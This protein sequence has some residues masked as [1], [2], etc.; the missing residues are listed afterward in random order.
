M[1][2]TENYS[3]NKPESTDYVNVDDLND[4]ADT[5]DTQLHSH[6]LAIST[7]QNRP[8]IKTVSLMNGY[9]TVTDNDGNTTKYALTA[10]T[11]TLSLSV[12]LNGAE[13][14]DITDETTITVTDNDGNTIATFSGTELAGINEETE[15]ET[16]E[17]TET[18]D[19]ETNTSGEV[20]VNGD[21]GNYLITIVFN[22]VS[23]VT[24]TIS[25]SLDGETYTQSE[26]VNVDLVVDG[27]TIYIKADYAES[28]EE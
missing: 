21:V 3:M 14:T 16:E 18:E 8:T 11:G 5:I 2:Y 27:V 17:D 4:N 24:P 22:S 28:E 9:L 20:S 7:L 19:T 25:Y 10:E 1:Q 23:E 6:E 26:T 12:A 15:T 13:W